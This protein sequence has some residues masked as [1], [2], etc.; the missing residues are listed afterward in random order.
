MGGAG[1]GP[2]VIVT[3]LSFA[4]YGFWPAQMAGMPDN[5]YNKSMWPL[6]I[7]FGL[8]LL[9]YAIRT[10]KAGLSLTASPFLTPYLTIH[11]YAPAL[12]G[13]GVNS[14]EFALVCVALWAMKLFMLY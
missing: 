7:P 2:L 3:L 10:R 5:P 6:S 1:F 12:L 14:V 11:S 4:L 13:M 9:L 8:A